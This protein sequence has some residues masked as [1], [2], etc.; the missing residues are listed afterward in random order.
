MQSCLRL[1][2]RAR[3]GFTPGSLFIRFIY[4]SGHLKAGGSLVKGWGEVKRKCLTQFGGC[5]LLSLIK[6]T[7]RNPVVFCTLLLFF[8]CFRYFYQTETL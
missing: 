8:S 2:R 3:P 7:L 6:P 1:Q 4:E 5:P